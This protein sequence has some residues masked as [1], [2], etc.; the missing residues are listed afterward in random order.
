MAEV[1]VKIFPISRSSA[2]VR[3]SL[4]ANDVN[5]VNTRRI[6]RLYCRLCMEICIHH[7]IMQ[8]RRWEERP[9]VRNPSRIRPFI[10]PLAELT[11]RILTPVNS[12][13]K[14]W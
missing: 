8:S 3:L 7:S 1:V 5:L 4:P 14:K 9:G 13:V 2:T 11:A 12:G 10:F 6:T